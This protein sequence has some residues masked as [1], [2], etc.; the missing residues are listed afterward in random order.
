MLHHVTL[1]AHPRP[2]NYIHFPPRINVSLVLISTTP[3]T[4]TISCIRHKRK[5]FLNIYH[6]RLYLWHNQH[7]QHLL[8]ST[9]TK[10]KHI[11][12]QWLCL[13]QNRYHQSLQRSSI[14]HNQHSTPILHHNQRLHLYHGTRL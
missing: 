4:I 10:P 11:R 2:I 12:I 14:H 8:H 6:R 9:N 13:L 1:L 7:H 5:T 3:T